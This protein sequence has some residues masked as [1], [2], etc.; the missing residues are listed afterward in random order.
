M[1]IILGVDP[2]TT[3]CGWGLVEVVHGVLEHRDHGVWESPT[4][5][6]Q[7]QRLVRLSDQITVFLQSRTIAAAAVERLFFGN[8]ASITDI[9]EA[10]GIILERLERFAI[11]TFNYPPQTI[12]AALSHGRASKK[13]VH[14]P[15]ALYFDLAKPPKPDDAADALAAAVCHFQHAPF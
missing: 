10:R 5:T 3:R 9:I 6:T 4:D 8:A 2:G 12:K 15:V 1:T 7:G 14:Q 13:E 11:P